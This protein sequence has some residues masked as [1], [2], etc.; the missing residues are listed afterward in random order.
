GV[1]LMSSSY[2]TP[3]HSAF[4]RWCCGLI[5]MLSYEDIL[6]ITVYLP[7]MLFMAGPA[8]IVANNPWIT[9]VITAIVGFA[10]SWVL[11][12]LGH[13]LLRVL[14]KE[15]KVVYLSTSMRLPVHLSLTQFVWM[16][17]IS[18]AVAVFSAVVGKR[19]FLVGGGLEVPTSA[20]F[21]VVG[22]GLYFLPVYLA[23]L[24]IK[25]YYSIL[26]LLRPTEEVVNKSLSVVR[27]H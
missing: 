18:V 16:M 13:R 20:I 10:F 21:V 25:K 12:R 24:W 17:E 6:S 11:H 22:L 9:L 15:P 2:A 23:R 19:F 8:A 7:P 14:P 5:Q 1:L 3:K 27:F 4:T 26:P